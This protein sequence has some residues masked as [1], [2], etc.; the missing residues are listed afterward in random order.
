M[1]QG[2]VHRTARR[3]LDGD[4]KAADR[5]GSSHRDRVRQRVKGEKVALTGFGIFEK[6][7]R[8]ARIAR[9]PAP[10]PACGSRRPRFRRSAPAPSSRRSSAAPR[11]WPRSPAKKAAPAAKAARGQDGRGRQGRSGQEGRC[12]PQGRRPRPRRR[13]GRTGDEGHRGQDA[14]RPRLRPRPRRRRPLPARPATKA[15]AKKAAAGKTA[16]GQEGRCASSTTGQARHAPRSTTSRHD[17]RR[18]RLPPGS[19]PVWPSLPPGAG[20]ATR[21]R[22]VG[23]SRS[24]RPAAVPRPDTQKARLRRSPRSCASG[25]QLVVEQPGDRL[26][27]AGDHG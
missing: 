20:V 23:R 24:T 21:V 11:R 22:P 5:A 12:R 10:V 16:A 27:L 1:K 6:R 26:A 3:P 15:P 14:A 2:P 7:D 25:R 19:S 18:I 17:G 13:Q 9:N 8:A 4:K